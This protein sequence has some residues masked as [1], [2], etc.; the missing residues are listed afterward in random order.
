MRKL[1]SGVITIRC[2]DCHEVNKHHTRDLDSMSGDDS[3]G[4]CGSDNTLITSLTDKIWTQDIADSS[5]A[6]QLG[7]V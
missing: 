3:C 1:R 5:A 6:K 4:F 2:E 7:L